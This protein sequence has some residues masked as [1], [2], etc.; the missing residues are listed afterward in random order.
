MQVV[1][2]SPHQAG[3][4]QHTGTS[5][6]GITI[7]DFATLTPAQYAAAARVLR[8][9]LAH[10]PSAFGGPGVAEAEIE[11]RR[12]DSDWL[13]FAALDRGAVAG[14]IGAIRT[15]SHAWELHPLVVDLL[16]QRR[17]VGSALLVRLEAH[18]RAAGVLTVHL[19]CGDDYGGTNLFG[20]DLFPD[21]MDAAASIKT[22][23]RGHAFTFYR[24]HGYE[25]VGL[26]P[27]VDGP[28]CHDILMA[29]QLVGRAQD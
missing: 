2:A 13:G 25:I 1:I 22:A 10:Q 23:G 9:A 16:H 18:A 20:R 15:Y 14:W 26:L 6:M 24:R 27:D 4:Y 7:V 11:S 28:G 12:A 17:G 3:R 19:G 5:A 29:K 21:V 8:E